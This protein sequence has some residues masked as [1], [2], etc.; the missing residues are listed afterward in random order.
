MYREP[1]EEQ[2]IALLC[3]WW[4]YEAQYSPVKGYPSECPSARDYRTSRQYDDTNGAAETDSRGREAARIGFIVRC[5]PR[6][7]Q[8]ALELLAR[9]RVLQREDWGTMELPLDPL[10]RARVVA[11]ALEAFGLLHEE[12]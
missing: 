10:E 1:L 4:K 9:N 7:Q 6:Q 5:L 3:L 8:K 11:N 2:W 12:G